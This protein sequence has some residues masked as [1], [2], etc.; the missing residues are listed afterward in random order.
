MP[1]ILFTLNLQPEQLLRYYKG[2]SR[3]LQVVTEDG[4]NLRFPL[5]K[6]R[7]FVTAEGVQGRFLMRYDE[8]GR[9][10]SLTRH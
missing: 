8:T 1:D 2:S 9:F 4:R 5:E 6:L 3:Y 7:P 10:L